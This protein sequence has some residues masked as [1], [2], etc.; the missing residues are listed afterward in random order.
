MINGYGYKTSTLNFVRYWYCSS[1]CDS[2]C[3]TPNQMKSC[4][5][6]VFFM[7]NAYIT[8]SM[9]SSSKRKRRTVSRPMKPYENCMCSLFNENFLLFCSEMSLCIQSNWK[10]SRDEEWKE[11]VQEFNAMRGWMSQL[12]TNA[13]MYFDYIVL[14]STSFHD[15]FLVAIKFLS[16]TRSKTKKYFVC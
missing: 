4:T 12:V 10:G 3:A 14:H 2:I 11:I 7:L 13:I 9:L 1:T 8:F 15:I 16:K 6:A 5:N